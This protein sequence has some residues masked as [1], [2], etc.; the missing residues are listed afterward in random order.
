MKT[1]SRLLKFTKRLL[2]LLLLAASPGSFRRDK[3]VD[4]IYNDIRTARMRVNKTIPLSLYITG[5]PLR[6]WYLMQPKMCCRCC[7]ED[8]LVRECRTA[9]CFNC[10]MPGHQADECTSPALCSVCL[11]ESHPAI[12]CPFLFLSTNIKENP[13]NASYANVAKTMTRK[14]DGLLSYA[15]AASRFPEQVE[16]IKAVGAASGSSLA[17]RALAKIAA[18]NTKSQKS[19]QKPSQKSSKSSQ[20]SPQKEKKSERMST[21][22]E[23]NSESNRVRERCKHDRDR[24]CNKC[25]V[26]PFR[27]LLQGTRSFQRL[28]STKR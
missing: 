2:I 23:S 12:S 8:H 18:A 19:A 9:R 21:E 10:E 28:L 14:T 6:I 27:R 24:D 1:T 5:E 17:S 7:A 22:S 3:V 26:S 15:S 11:D 25:H 4:C 16:A 13:G 20:N